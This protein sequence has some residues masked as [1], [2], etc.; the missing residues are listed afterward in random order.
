MGFGFNLFFIFILIPGTFILL[1][2]G[3]ATRKS[4]FGYLLG[5]MWSGVIAIILL[6]L[7]LRPFTTPK[8]VTTE[9]IYGEYIIDRTKFPGP[10]ADWQYD[11]FK[12]SITKTNLLLFSYKRGDGNFTT[13]TIPVDFLDQYYSH[14]LIIGK[15]KKRHH[16]IQD[17]PTLYRK[18]WSFYYVFYSEQYGNMFFTK[19]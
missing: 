8:K 5:L 16:I 9:K 12:F 7:L 17:N 1:L 18:T 13:D 6:S 15:D 19:K 4:I 2:L 11:N 14:R 3:I 10:Q